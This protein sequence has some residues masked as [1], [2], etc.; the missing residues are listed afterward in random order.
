[1]HADVEDAVETS[2]PAGGCPIATIAVGKQ[3]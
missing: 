3:I 2:I 1:V